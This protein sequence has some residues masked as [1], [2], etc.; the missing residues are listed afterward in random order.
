MRTRLIRLLKF[1]LVSHF[2]VLWRYVPRDW[3]ISHPELSIP[4]FPQLIQHP[5]DS[6]G[7]ITMN[8]SRKII[9]NLVSS[10][11]F[12]QALCQPAILA[13]KL[14]LLGNLLNLELV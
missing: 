9:K 1:G 11:S 3:P 8:D 2:V 14:P 6:D 13:R 12:P 5:C 10:N 7:L 4:F